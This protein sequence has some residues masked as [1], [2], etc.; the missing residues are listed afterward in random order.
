[1][2]QFSIVFICC[3]LVGC[4]RLESYI[5]KTAD[6]VKL[7]PTIVVEPP[8][9]IIN[10][11]SINPINTNNQNAQVN[12][13]TTTTTTASATPLFPTSSTPLNSQPSKKICRRKKNCPGGICSSAQKE[14]DSL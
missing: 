9:V 2:K 14:E 6:E 10:T 11:T 3:L 8:N 1:M 4:A 5:R 13:S 12:K 7:E